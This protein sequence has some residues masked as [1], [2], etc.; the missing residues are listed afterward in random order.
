[1]QSDVVVLLA[2]LLIAGSLF[3]A[4]TV[5]IRGLPAI[6]RG[7]DFGAVVSA[8]LIFVGFLLLT[9]IAPSSISRAEPPRAMALEPSTEV[10]DR[11]WFV[12]R[13]W[14]SFRLVLLLAIGPALIGLALATVHRPVQVVPKD[15][16][17]PD[18]S[19]ER[20]ITMHPSYTTYVITT[21]RSGSQRMREATA[22]EIA[23]RPVQMGRSRFTLLT[24]GFLAVLTVLAHGAWIVGLGLA[25]GIAFRDRRRALSA[26]ASPFIIVSVL[27][28]ILYLFLYVDLGHPPYPP[29][30]CLASSVPSIV[31]LLL[32]HPPREDR[33]GELIGWV[34]FW[35]ALLILLAVAVSVLAIWTLEAQASSVFRAP[36]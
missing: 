32:D 13:W 27:W 1:M 10:R 33:L 34:T 35:D 28:P 25:V 6:N 29:G 26:S 12:G 4:L 7:M 22:A 24:T 2:G 23:A 36:A 8:L 21:D 17:F 18:G 11:R 19:T 16:A 9:M 20:I 15:T 5:W 30:L 14:E 3:G 31:V